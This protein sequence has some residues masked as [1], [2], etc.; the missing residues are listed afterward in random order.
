MVNG[1]IESYDG[2]DDFVFLREL[3]EASFVE[4][5]WAFHG[6]LVSCPGREQGA[7]VPFLPH[8]DG[9]NTRENTVMA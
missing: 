9:F 3:V 4:E 5:T 2:R 1:V 7:M 8:D 6:R